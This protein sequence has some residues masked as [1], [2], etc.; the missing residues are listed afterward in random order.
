MHA[1]CISGRCSL[2]L[3]AQAVRLTNNPVPAMKLQI[4]FT[5][6]MFLLIFE[7]SIVVRIED[8]LAN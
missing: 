4:A 2:P 5:E 1:V 8:G 6:N 3:E 7:K